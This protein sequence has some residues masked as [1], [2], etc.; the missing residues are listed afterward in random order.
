ML[1]VEQN[2]AKA[3]CVADRGSVLELDRNRRNRRSWWAR[4]SSASTLAAT[5]SPTRDK[6]VRFLPGIPGSYRHSTVM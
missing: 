5:T 3:L 2:A 1:V 4:M 6:R